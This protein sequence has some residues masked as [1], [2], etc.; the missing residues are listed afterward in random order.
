V[1]NATQLGTND[2]K[3]L[4][5]LVAET[6][7]K[8]GK[9]SKD[10]FIFVINKMDAFDPEKGED[11]PS[12]LARV[13]KYLVENG[14]FNPL[15]YPVSANLTRLLRKPQHLHSRKERGELNS[16]MDM[17]SEEPSMN[18]LQY[19]PI[20]NRVK[21][22]LHEKKLPD[23]FLK[24][25]LPAVEAMI[26]EYIDKYNFPHRVKRA[27]DAMTKAIEV[28]LNETHLIAQ[29]DQD[30]KTLAHINEEIQA[31]EYRQEKGFDTQ[32]YKDRI[33]REGKVLPAAT[34][35]E[36][37]MLESKVGQYLRIASDRLMGIVEPSLAEVRVKAVE[38]ELQFQYRKLINEYEALFKSSQKII[39]DDLE[40][41]YQLYILDLFKDCKHLKLPILES[42]QKAAS[43]ISFN[44]TVKPQDIKTKEVVVDSY[45][46]SDSTWYNPFSW[47]STHTVYKYGE[48]KSVDLGNLWKGRAAPVEAE[49]SRLVAAGRE[50]I[51]AGQNVLI[52]QFL[53]FMGRE[54][55]IKFNELLDSLKEKMTDR[56]ARE[57]ALREARELQ[58]WIS[59]FKNKLDDTLA[60]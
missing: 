53:A 41:E 49:F 4:L 19:M 50:E 40:A 8:G 34:A 33:A 36:L 38:E 52:D 12:V 6:M 16:M 25:G 47:G 14:I 3:R 54:F 48:E 30:E 37:N 60:V 15:I 42:I 18:L 32:A 59:Q 7:R 13:H 17:F 31:L 29:L 58:A 11:L 35:Q 24:S 2:D 39:R 5:G 56:T 57:K 1:L 23:I 27:Y 26:D 21:R 45:E 55:E 20:T 43:D 44:L 9:Q 22:N 51:N 28:G 46:V 10:R